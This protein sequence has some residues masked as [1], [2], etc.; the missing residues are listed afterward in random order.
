MN[1]FT[2]YLRTLTDTQVQNCYRKEVS[3]GHTE[4]AAF[5]EAE[6]YRRGIEVPDEDDCGEEHWR[7][8]FSRTTRQY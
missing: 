7:E 1:E 8:S 3:L 6:C 5:A 2:A 4:D